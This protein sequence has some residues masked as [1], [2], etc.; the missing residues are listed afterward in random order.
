MRNWNW[1]FLCK[2]CKFLDCLS[3][4]YEELKLISLLVTF[5][6]FWI[7]YRVPMRNWNTTFSFTLNFINFVYRVPMRNWNLYS[8]SITFVNTFSLSRT[9]EEL[10]PRLINCL[11][12]VLLG[13]SRTY[14]ELKLF[15]P[16]TTSIFSFLF[17]A[18]LWG[19]ETILGS[20]FLIRTQKSLS[21]TYEELKH[22]WTCK[23]FF[24]K[25]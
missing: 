16:S 18:Y 10:K 7:V 11:N 12:L 23:K 3:R 14:E 19:I 9:Y 17:I 2:D 6:F 25:K 4:T 15:Q 24:V 1:L 13:L 21:R 20:N 8:I 22:L 5:Q